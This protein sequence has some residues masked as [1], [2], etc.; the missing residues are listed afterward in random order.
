M[1]HTL[2]VNV[3][4]CW[5]EDQHPVYLLTKAD[6]LDDNVNTPSYVLT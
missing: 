2:C 5:E 6:Y 1:K 4:K 3:F